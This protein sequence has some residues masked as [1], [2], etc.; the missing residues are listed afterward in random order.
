M[1][2]RRSPIGEDRAGSSTKIV[3]FGGK[4]ENPW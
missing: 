4:V 1:Y 3:I 2:E